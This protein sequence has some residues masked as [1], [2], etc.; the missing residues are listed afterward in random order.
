MVLIPFAVIA[1]RRTRLV[2]WSLLGFAA[3]L[4]AEVFAY[5]NELGP[6]AHGVIGYHVTALGN[7]HWSTRANLH[8]LRHYLDWHTPF[9]WLFAAGVVAM[10]WLVLRRAQ[11]VRVL[12]VLWLLVPCAAAFV[13]ALKP[14]FPHHLVTL[15]VALAL[16]AGAWIG[17]AAARA[18]RGVG[19]A[20]AVGAIAFVVIGGYQQ[21]RWAARVPAQPAYIYAAAAWL[22]AAS[23]PD[24]IVATDMPI[25]AYYAHRRVVPDMVDSTFTRLYIGELT[26]KSVFAN[27]DRYH[28]RA[29][30]IGRVFY[31]DHGS[32]TRSTPGSDT[33]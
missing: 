5:R 23:R 19:A 1:I 31:A 2:L 33:A 3:I 27:L 4:G 25:V 12:A 17:V 22:R 16:P 8:V 9:A 28:V 20:C 6:I 29:A 18:P 24:E 15:A 21:H 30:V 10:V 26:P 14:L 11:E 7:Q 32:A 13:L